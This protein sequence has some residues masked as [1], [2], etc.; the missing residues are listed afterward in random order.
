MLGAGAVTGS[1]NHPI[2]GCEIDAKH[3]IWLL[4]LRVNP[5]P[6]VPFWQP[7]ALQASPGLFGWT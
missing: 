2:L 7:V 1:W 3:K 4:R 6:C 5:G